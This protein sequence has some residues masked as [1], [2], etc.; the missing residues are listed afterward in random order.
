MEE[1]KKEGLHPQAYEEVPADQYPPYMPFDVQAKEFSVRGVIT[2]VLFGIMF[3]A[4]N[5]YL[6]LRAGLTISTSI[7]I[8]VLT[9]MAF[10]VLPPF[11]RIGSILEANISQTIGSA[12]S[13]LA[14]GMIFTIPALFLWGYNPSLSTLI[15][16]SVCGGLLGVLFM[17][18]LRKFLIRGEHGRLPYPEGTA[19]A[20]VLVTADRGGTDSWPIFQGMLLGGIVKLLS[21]A[22]HIWKSYF[23]LDLPFLPRGR[24]ALDASPALLGVGYILGF[25]ISTIM[26][27]GGLLASLIL[28]PGIAIWGADLIQ[29]LYPETE[30][31][32]RDMTPPLIWTRYIRYVGAGAVASAG[33]LTLIQSLPTIWRSF[34][35]GMK[36]LKNGADGNPESVVRSN[37]DL[38]LSTVAIGAGIVT[39]FLAISPNVLGF[40]DSF[41]ARI[42]SAILISFFAF[43]FVT[44]SSRIVGMV[45][46]TSN[47]TSGM[48]IATL[49]GTSLVFLLLGWKGPQAMAQALIMGAVVATAASTAGDTSQDLKAGFLIGADS[50]KQQIGELLGVVTAATFVCL[51][52]FAL[53]KSYGFG[54]EELPAPQAI[55]MKLVIE[56]VFNQAIPWTFVLI[57]VGLTLVAAI[58]KLPTL[59]LAVGIY[60]PL[61]TTMPVFIG[62]LIRWIVERGAK[63]NAKALARRRE[64]GVLFGSGLVGG[65]GLL[66]VGIAAFALFVGRR[67]QGIDPNWAG[68]FAEWLPLLIFGGL[69]WFLYSSTK[70]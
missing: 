12:S 53:H 66:G 22:L 45:G 34:Q 23:K 62:G 54:T 68:A 42:I 2:G 59:A 16:V 43:F 5:A 69:V 60:L 41:Q 70:K 24:L 27:G 17:V 26:V 8:A 19:T 28:I 3:G 6:G 67:P 25:K 15:T 61:S 44:V 64:K 33:I 37:R 1:A 4:A 20:E 65:E 58:F 21:G 30:K 10:L 7:P 49:L 39:L 31:L 35:I 55:M 52:V 18:P 36:H 32:I 50:R 29:P 51:A 63:G 40:V 57:G 13:S 48:T 46:V 11:G 38:K 9:V 47:P 14:S 56:G